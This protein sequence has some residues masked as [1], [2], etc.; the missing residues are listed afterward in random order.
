MRDDAG[1]GGGTASKAGE[2]EE[3]AS[4][5]D[6]ENAEESLA[7]AASARI[8]LAGEVDGVAAEPTAATASLFVGAPE[9]EMAA[10][11][12]AAAAVL[13]ARI[14]STF[15]FSRRDALVDFA[16]FGSVFC[17]EAKKSQYFAPTHHWLCID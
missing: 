1:F 3:A 11:A 9:E 10:S 14:R 15:F 17:R 4:G 13:S 6:G 8:L 7:E 12:A 5:G 2:V 16:I